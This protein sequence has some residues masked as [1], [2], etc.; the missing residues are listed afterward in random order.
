M[1]FWFFGFFIICLFVSSS[2]SLLICL[3]DTK[4]LLFGGVYYFGFGFGF[5][6]LV[7]GL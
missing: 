3:F 7:H 4:L 5:G 6:E 2:S 1:G